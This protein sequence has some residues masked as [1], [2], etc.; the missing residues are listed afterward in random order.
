MSLQAQCNICAEKAT[1]QG[2]MFVHTLAKFDDA[3]RGSA[4]GCQIVDLRAHSK[5]ILVTYSVVNCVDFNSSYD[6]Q[7]PY[8]AIRVDI[9]T[10]RCSDR[11]LAQLIRN[12]VF[13]CFLVY[14]R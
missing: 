10:K 4:C 2:R 8:H 14:L 7:L 5:V 9:K 11:L 1:R 13:L 12:Q 6:V 3:R